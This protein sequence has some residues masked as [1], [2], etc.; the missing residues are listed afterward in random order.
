MLMHGTQCRRAQPPPLC[1]PTPAHRGLQILLPGCL[2][3]LCSGCFKLAP[4]LPLGLHSFQWLASPESSDDSSWASTCWDAL[5]TPAG[6]GSSTSA[7][8]NAS[9]ACAAGQASWKA[10]G[11][12]AV[13]GAVPLV[14]PSGLQ[15]QTCQILG[16]PS[17]QQ[18]QPEALSA[19]AA[20]CIVSP[21]V[22]L[23]GSGQVGETTARSAV[24]CCAQCK[25]QCSLW[26]WCG[27][28]G[29]SGAAAQGSPSSPPDD[30]DHSAAPSGSGGGSGC[31]LASGRRLAP[32]ACLL[33]RSEEIEDAQPPLVVAQGAGVGVTSGSPLS[34]AVLAAPEVPGYVVL[35]GR[36][37]KD[38]YDYRCEGSL[39]GAECKLSG[40]PASLAA[41]C[42][43]D[44]RCRGFT[45]FPEGS[46]AGGSLAYLSG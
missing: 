8:G 41:R 30:D 46:G 17:R 1:K 32:G 24:D 18:G 45:F 13:S 19:A 36:E 14:C 26:L 25:G 23:Q 12:K 29:G 6:G 33:L 11:L 10:A 42:S 9:A 20:Q 35:R 3:R 15:G 43:A 44:P 34:Q 40:Q 38:L 28:A 37:V 2:S 31:T 27:G 16:G 21:G 5:I 39:V 7:A 22:E 4:D